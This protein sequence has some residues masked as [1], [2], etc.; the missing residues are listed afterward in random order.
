MTRLGHQL[1][2]DLNTN[3]T[4]PRLALFPSRAARNIIP[5]VQYTVLLEFKESTPSL[6]RLPPL[7]LPQCDITPSSDFPSHFPW[8]FLGTLFTSRLVLELSVFMSFLSVF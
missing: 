5:Q 7:L 3:P 4:D 1:V 6:P 2:V 8:I